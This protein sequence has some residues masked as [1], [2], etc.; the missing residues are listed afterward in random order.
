MLVFCPG[1][2]NHVFMRK[3]TEY[4]MHQLE[5]SC[6]NIIKLCVIQWLVSLARLLLI[7]KKGKKF[8]HESSSQA[9]TTNT[10][11][12]Y[13]KCDKAIGD[14]KNLLQINRDHAVV[15]AI[16]DV[17]SMIT[18]F[19]CYFHIMQRRCTEFS[20]PLALPYENHTTS[21]VHTELYCRA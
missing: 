20:L 3:K 10:L 15:I 8:A 16:Y 5:Q 14:S 17:S 11:R 9:H 7:Q 6:R 12:E 4:H 1:A 2:P 13:H 18:P 21:C 19:K